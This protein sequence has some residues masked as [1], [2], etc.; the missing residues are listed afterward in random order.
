MSASLHLVSL[1][2]IFLLGQ[3]AFP[4][5][6]LAEEGESPHPYPVDVTAQTLADSNATSR[7][8]KPGRILFEEGFNKPDALDRFFNLLGKDRGA[9]EI[10][11]DPSFAHSGDG[12]FQLHTIDTGG[13]SV[14]GS[15]SYWLD[16]GADTLYFRR[17]IRFAEDYDQ[18]NLHHVG[19][20]LAAV[21]GD[22]P[23]GGMGHA[24]QRPL[25]DDRFTAGFEPWRAFGRNASP[26]MM[27]LYTYW[28]DMKVSR[29]G[30]HYYGN[31]FIPENGVVLDR[32]VWHCLEH[33]LISNTPG[34]ADGEMAAWID[35]KLYIHIKGLPL[36]IDAGCT[37][38]RVRTR[39][40]SGTM[41]LSCRLDTSDR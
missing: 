36:A 27:S 39:M 18:G 40:S 9:Q 8:E 4:R 10:V 32:D 26:G 12:C 22:D 6:V 25:G 11:M 20:S 38:I 14:G 28:M 3:V 41:M 35:G 23:F 31:Q 29:D 34:E 17:Y 1:I 15:A 13:K 19:G 21:S 2:L 5:P 37:S 16:E 7:L 33:A 30:E 24:G